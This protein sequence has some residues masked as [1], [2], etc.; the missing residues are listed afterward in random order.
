MA[1]Q[2]FHYQ[3]NAM[4]RPR[5]SFENDASG[6]TGDDLP[7]SH[8][9]IIFIDPERRLRVQCSSSL[10]EQI[11]TVLTTEV[12]RN[13]LR[14]L[15][16]NFGFQEPDACNHPRRAKRRQN[17]LD[18][19]TTK[20]PADDSVPRISDGDDFFPRG[21]ETVT[22]RV[23]DTQEI[24]KYYESALD[25]FQQRNCGVIAKAFIK[26][27]EPCK[28]T[29]HP[30]N[31]GKPPSGSTPGSTGDPEKTKPKWWPPGVRHKEPDHLHKA[32]RIQLLL[33]I[34]RKLGDDRITTDKLKELAGDTKRSL[35]DPS[36]VAIIFEILRVRQIEQRY[37]RG[38]I[39][40]HTPVYVVRR[41]TG[42]KNG[43][44][45]G[46]PGG[47]DGPTVTDGAAEHIEE[48]LLTPSSFIEQSIDP[49]TTPID[50]MGV[51]LY[52]L[53][54]SFTP[55]EPLNLRG[56]SFYTTSPQ[57]IDQFSQSLHSIPVT[58]EIT[59]PYNPSVFNY[60]SQ[61]PFRP[62]TASLQSGG[63]LSAYGA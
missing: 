48:G 5:H 57:F 32:E 20:S 42:P 27:I 16:Q 11:S 3:T 63:L 45:K 21:H 12:Q 49:S 14:T 7:Y 24:I 30:Y 50:E 52:S 23:G 18:S 61:N 13:F 47:A 31:G 29:R 40:A 28:K 59:N 41:E 9:A 60:P 37:E 19:V 43:V 53:P 1:S 54:G 46:S 55:A 2:Q 22:L 38:E 34:I 33:H 35:T 56:H 51:S 58:T 39:D 10:R 8:Y 36:H 6:Q 25:H 17:T 4:K 62:W 44:V 26:T 15:N